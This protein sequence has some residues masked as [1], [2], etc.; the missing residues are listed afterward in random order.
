[1]GGDIFLSGFFSLEAETRGV[2]VSFYIQ[3]IVVA[4]RCRCVTSLVQIKGF[5]YLGLK[6]TTCTI[7]PPAFAEIFIFAFFSGGGIL[8]S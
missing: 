4:C 1:M 8:G 7:F 3:S 5:Y 2:L 6:D